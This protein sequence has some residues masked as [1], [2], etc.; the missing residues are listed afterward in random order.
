MT[1]TA[2]LVD[3]ELLR[4]EAPN[5]ISYAYRRFGNAAA[6]VPVVF[7]QHFRGNID[8]WD[9]ALPGRLH[10]PGDRPD[11]SRRC[12]PPH[13]G[14]HGAEGRPGHAGVDTGRGQ[15]RGIGRRRLPG[16]L[17][18]H[19][20]LTIYPD[21]SHGSIFQYAAEAASETLAFLSV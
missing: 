1:A 6:G 15:E 11:A 17:I 20:K 14:W 10:R 18:P 2:G 21:A 12:P 19:A 9:P 8:N 3:A 13:P 7:L 5:G 4:V 16:R